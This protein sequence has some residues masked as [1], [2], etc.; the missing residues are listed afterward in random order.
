[1]RAQTLGETLATP[2]LLHPLDFENRERFAQRFNSIHILK[3]VVDRA[4]DRAL[5]LFQVNFGNIFAA[6]QPENC[7]DYVLVAFIDDG[8]VVAGVADFSSFVGDYVPAGR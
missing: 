4:G 2:R 7:E 6:A 8:G 5:A 1:M 3:V